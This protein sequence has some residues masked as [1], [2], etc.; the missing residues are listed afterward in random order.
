M[1]LPKS[2]THIDGVIF[3][4]CPDE[5]V[6]YADEGTYA[7]EH[8]EDEEL[9]DGEFLRNW[10]GSIYALVDEPDEDSET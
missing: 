4:G 9:I 5:M 6:V 8:C 2:I 7:A 1:A 10:D 3:R